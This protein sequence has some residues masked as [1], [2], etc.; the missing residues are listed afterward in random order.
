MIN[1]VNFTGHRPNKLG[2]YNESNHLNIWVKRALVKSIVW[3]HKK[4]G[5]TEWI[6][7]AALGVDQWAA[8]IILYLK[9]NHDYDFKLVIMKP[10]HSCDSNWPIESRNRLAKICENADEVIDVQPE[11]YA[12]WKMLYRNK[13]MVKRSDMTIAVWDGSDGGT[14]HCVKQ[15]MIHKHPILKIC[16]YRRIFSWIDINTG[17]ELLEDELN[18]TKNS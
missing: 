15:A 16:P 8:E 10:F 11:P 1:S 9:I 2:G 3:S 7:G 5:I 17:N 6:S 18:G 12:A 14:A 13:E 4:F